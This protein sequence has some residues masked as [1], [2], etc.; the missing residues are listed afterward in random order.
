MCR[1]E[2]DIKQTFSQ[3]DIENYRLKQQVGDISFE[4]TH[5]MQQFVDLEK[6]QKEQ[7]FIIGL[8]ENGPLG[9]P[10]SPDLQQDPLEDNGPRPQSQQ[11]Q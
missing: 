6:K 3:Q 5:M 9:A 11:Q 10:S 4:R 7:E 2:E 8:D 1:I